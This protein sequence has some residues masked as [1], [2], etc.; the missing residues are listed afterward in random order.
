[1]IEQQPKRADA[2]V[3]LFSC[4]FTFLV[5]ISSLAHMYSCDGG[6]SNGGLLVWPKIELQPIKFR[7]THVRKLIIL[8]R[9]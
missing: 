8:R 1:M 4:L 9:K 6:C 2:K 3:V 5:E 7:V